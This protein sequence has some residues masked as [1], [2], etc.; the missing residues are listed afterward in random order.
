MVSNKAHNPNNRQA[1]LA[2]LKIPRGKEIAEFSVQ[3]LP[4]HSASLSSKP[5]QWVLEAACS[6]VV[7]ISRRTLL[8]VQAC[9]VVAL[10]CLDRTNLPKVNHPLIRFLAVLKLSSNNNNRKRVLCSDQ[11]NNSSPNNNRLVCLEAIT[12]SK[13]ILVEAAELQAYLVEAQLAH[14]INPSTN[15]SSNNN[16]AYLVVNNRLSSPVRL[17]L[18]QALLRISSQ[19]HFSEEPSQQAKALRCLAA[20]Q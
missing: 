18:A 2:A 7:E 3:I 12:S 11:I 9:L 17:F 19:A 8:E 4:A 14:K 10:P 13:A 6:V 1:F 15:H 5:Q 20:L 16:Q